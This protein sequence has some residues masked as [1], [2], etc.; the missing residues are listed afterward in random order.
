MM[1]FAFKMM[2]FVLTMMNFAFKMMKFVL[3]MM[4][5]AFKMMKFQRTLTS[6]AGGKP[7]V[8]QTLHLSC[9]MVLQLCVKS[10]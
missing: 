3:T 9:L 6:W 5:F 4:N 8:K 10:V 7:F 2:N 1:N